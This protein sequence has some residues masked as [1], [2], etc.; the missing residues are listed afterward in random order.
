MNRAIPF[1]SASLLAFAPAAVLA[2]QTDGIER[3]ELESV[4]E[5]VT[6]EEAVL[7]YVN[8]MAPP[9]SVE[10]TP[11]LTPSELAY[12]SE[13]NLNRAV[14]ALEEALAS[15]IAMRHELEQRIGP[16]PGTWTI[17]QEWLRAYNNCVLQRHREAR[18]LETA[19]NTRRAEI[20][21]NG[22]D[23]GATLLTGLIDR[24]VTRHSKAKVAI[25]EEMRMVPKLFSFYR[26]GK[27]DYALEGSGEAVTN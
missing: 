3:E 18:S 2:Q 11:I 27:A 8:Y 25:A 9:E 21:A 1:L 23:E 13:I 26:T 7:T 5:I 24:I 22:E 4:D 19:I 14:S 12:A 16:K 15:C 20:I 6:E 10:A 17:N